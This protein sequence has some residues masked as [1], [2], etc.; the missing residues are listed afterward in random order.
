[1]KKWAEMYSLG[2]D[3]L[4]KDHQRL[5]RVAE[6]IAEKVD[7]PYTDPKK[8]PFLVREG[9]KYIGGYYESHVAREEEYMRQ[10]NYPHYDVHRQVHD[11]LRTNAQAFISARITAEHCEKD[12]VLELLGASYGWQMVHIAT[13]DMDI[14]KK[15]ALSR[16]ATVYMGEESVTEELDA[17]LCELLGINARTHIDHLN[18]KGDNLSTAACQHVVYDIGGQEVSV[19]LGAETTF[20][21]NLTKIFWGE[22]IKKNELDK[23]HSILLQW[24]LTSF[25]IGFWRD[26]IVRLTH[27]KPCVM[28]SVSPLQIQDTEKAMKDMELK[29]SVLYGTTIGRFFFACN[30]GT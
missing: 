29:R 23:A 27:G 3:E 5:L 30:Y 7:D 28:K 13:D 1:M 2:I 11:E 26:L 14:V 22:K 6:Q 15:G 24:C 4:D 12:D 8:F 16:P 10:T 9:L 18:F 19:Y 17:M 21:S 25:I 20:L